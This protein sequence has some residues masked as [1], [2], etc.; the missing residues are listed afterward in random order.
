M[1][2]K[3]KFLAV[4]IPLSLVAG[5]GDSTIGLGDKEITLQITQS[6]Q[7]FSFITMTCK[8]KEPIM[9]E[10][11]V[12]NDKNIYYPITALPANPLKSTDISRIERF[13]TITAIE[14]HNDS[15]V[16]KIKARILPCVRGQKEYFLGAI[17]ISSDPQDHEV[18]EVTIN[19]TN[20]GSGTWT[21]NN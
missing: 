7:E 5:C 21:W 13:R 11:V 2:N 4:I 14:E 9:I 8:S 18:F 20:M 17:K 12:V 10:S 15:N 3:F 6:Y 1:I 16:S 19:S